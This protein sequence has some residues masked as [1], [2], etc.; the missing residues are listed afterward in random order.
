[1]NSF[2]L[3]ELEDDNLVDDQHISDIDDF[4]DDVEEQLHAIED[5]IKSVTSY[6]LTPEE[7]NSLSIDAKLKATVTS[8]TYDAIAREAQKKALKNYQQFLSPELS[9]LLI[10][11]ANIQREYGTANDH[12]TNDWEIDTSTASDLEIERAVIRLRK[13]L[14]HINSEIE[15]ISQENEKNNEKLQQIYS[16]NEK[17]EQMKNEQINV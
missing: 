12:K 17:L 8:R 2:T 16:Q 10:N 14:T 6:K 4:I 9:T 7:S 11:H 15:M 1:M 3:Q 5:D 13:K